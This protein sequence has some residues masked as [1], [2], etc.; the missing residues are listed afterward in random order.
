MANVLIENR[1]RDQ[2]DCGVVEVDG[3]A[4]RLKLGSADD[5]TGAPV[6]RLDNG[7]T[8]PGNVGEF[9]DDFPNPI[10][11]LPG[12]AWQAFLKDKTRGPVIQDWLET[13]AITVSG[14]R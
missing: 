11:E 5:S 6:V 12:K 3:E 7:S 13:R 1:E 8:R 14:A 4:Y 2:K 9:N 10:Q